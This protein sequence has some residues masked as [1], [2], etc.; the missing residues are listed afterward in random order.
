MSKTIIAFLKYRDFEWTGKKDLFRGDTLWVGYDA[1]K[2][3][4]DIEPVWDEV[5]VI[6]FLE[7]KLYEES[8]KQ[9]KLQEEK[10]EDYK[11]LLVDHLPQKMIN[12]INE[13]FEN[14]PKHSQDD[15]SRASSEEFGSR[16]DNPDLTEQLL[17][18]DKTQPIVVLNFYK[19]RD[20]AAYPDNYTKRKITGQIAYNRYT[21]VVQKFFPIFGVKIIVAGEFISSILGDIESD[22]DSYAFVRY[23]SLEVL[24]RMTN[25]KIYQKAFIHREAALENPVV[26]IS[27]TIKE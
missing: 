20:I 14:S 8:I 23:P 4:G 5:K 25:S 11:L 18:K 15:I 16:M 12:S 2:I 3:Y 24:E 22:W 26:Y 17:S 6:E 19:F 7:E 27:S 1:I 13:T 9:L 10:L 21:R